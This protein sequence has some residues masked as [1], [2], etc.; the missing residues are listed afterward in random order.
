[1]RTSHKGGMLVGYARVSTGDQNLALQKDALKKAGC[2]RLFTDI[3]S[4]AKDNAPAWPKRSPSFGR[5]TPSPS[6]SSTGW[7]AR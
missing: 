7:G 6:G 1:M 5:A 3:A 2:E 4:G